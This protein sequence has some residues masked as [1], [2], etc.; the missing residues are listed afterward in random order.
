M[1][2]PK[3][4]KDTFKVVKIFGPPTSIL[5]SNNMRIVQNWGYDQNINPE[6]YNEI[7]NDNIVST[8]YPGIT[9]DATVD[10][11]VSNLSLDNLREI[12]N[13]AAGAAVT[14][15]SFDNATCDILVP[16][17]EDGTNIT[18][19]L[20]LPYQFLTGYDVNF[21]VDGT[22]TESFR[23]SGGMDEEL[24]GD[25]AYATA[26]VFTS[27]T[28]V[29]SDT[30]IGP[31]TASGTEYTPVYAYVDGVKYSFAEAEVGMSGTNMNRVTISGVDATA[32]S[33]FT[34]IMASNTTTAFTQITGADS[35]IGGIRGDKVVAYL[36]DGS[37]PTTA[38]KWLRVQGVSFSFP[39]DR[40]EIREL[41]TSDPIDRSL[42]FPLQMTASVDIL[43]NDMERY[44][45]M[46]GQTFATVDV[47][48]PK[49]FQ[50][51]DDLYLT[52]VAYDDDPALSTAA[53]IL[54]IS[55]TGLRVNGRGSSLSVGGNA[56]VRWDF[57]F[58]AVNISRI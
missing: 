2:T 50:G 19:T 12:C 20:V 4:I 55:G 22:A 7:G 43:E 32:G 48:N 17:T 58:D 13:T 44:C 40:T 15:A 21:T 29:G 34:V 54:T 23:F 57:I 35:D 45:K 30:D 38:D 41:G 26:E 46:A 14:Q 8:D 49:Q 42:N 52:V 47:L 24:L 53:K 1:P 31:V 10:T 56:T 11:N 51:N 28:L 3:K 18:R 27:A 36:E 16:T 37:V 33:R 9:T 5:G 6:H 39:L 25:Y